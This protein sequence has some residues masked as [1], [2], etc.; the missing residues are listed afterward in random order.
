[1]SLQ[2]AAVLA[3][4]RPARRR[5]VTRAVSDG[6][7][8]GLS[9]T[10][11][12]DA[13]AILRGLKPVWFTPRRQ[14]VF[15]GEM[16]DAG[17]LSNALRRAFA[18][19]PLVDLDAVE[20]DL[21]AAIEAPCPSFF[22]E[23]MDVQII[24]LDEGGSAV[25]SLYDPHLV[26]VMQALGGRFHRYA[27]AWQIDG[28][29]DQVLERLER[30]AGIDPELVFVHAQPMRLEELAA[31][32]KAGMP[33]K[34]PAA[35]PPRS[36]GAAGDRSEIGSGFLSAFGAP[37]TRFAIDE[38]VIARAVT[39]CGL[40]DY[41]ADGV[42]HLL[43]RSSALLGDDM[44]LGK[45]R[46]AVVASRIA[47]GR[48]RI[49]V[50]CPATL[51]INWMREIKEVF[52]ADLVGV[53]G[54]DRVDMFKACRWVVTNF[55]RL[56]ALV[57]ERALHFA[58]MVVDEA[59]YLK[60]YQAGRTRNAFI[61]AERI[62]RRFL[63]TGTPILSREI[64]VHTLLRISGHPVGQLQLTEFRER[65]AGSPA[66]RAAL[67][68]VLADWMLRRPKSVLKN[69]G[70]K[71]RQFRFV[72]PGE[73]LDQ[74]RKVLADDTLTVMPKIVKLR[75]SLE[76]MKLDYI[77]QTIES[78]QTD[79][80]AIVF[81]EYMETVDA[82]RAAL[83]DAGIGVVSLVGA[84]SMK[85]RQAAV[86]AFQSDPAVRVFIGTTSAAGVGITLTAA[87]Y[88]FFA[89]QPW[90]PAMMRQA[91]DRAYRNG[92]RRDVFVIVPIVPN[93]IDQD[94]MRLLDDKTTLEQETVERAVA[95]RLSGAVAVA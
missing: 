11:V 78:L 58:V 93:T 21:Q 29:I 24:P 27:A 94:V 84:D 53:V 90:T 55:E 16:H 4:V 65:Y 87:N 44:G 17:R 61:M 80:K 40:Y 34:V 42:R 60:E 68:E 73:G 28:D 15:S 36:D 85:K 51:R 63:I 22:S 1:M 75:Q 76:A 9:V 57:R 18:Q 86:D 59:H 46:Q 39:H 10:P 77:A 41:Q 2:A 12:D 5:L 54:E 52:P 6:R 47:A 49:L 71:N 74:Y 32:P 43:G 82:L 37:M 83:G 64:E 33:I 13:S 23:A 19:R 35:T 88:V 38:A 69:L 7:R 72:E 81:C 67:A 92:Q 91:E 62:E 8:I 56:G 50:V 20:K 48:G 25:C 31:K 14:W 89:S 3:P 95:A 79:D 66:A 26:R 30:D 70:A 45:S